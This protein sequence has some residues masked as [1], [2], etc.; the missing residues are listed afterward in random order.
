MNRRIGGYYLIGALLLAGAGC[1]LRPIGWFLLW[2]AASLFVVAAGY[3]GI[4]A[5]VYGKRAGKLPLFPR[6]LHLFT[7]LGHELSRRHY[8][9]ACRPWCSLAPE[10]RIGRQLNETEAEELREEG[11]TAVLDLCAEFSEPARLRSLHYLNI[12]IL[13]LTA[14]TDEQ[15]RR[16]LDFLSERKDS[17]G[18]AYLH[19][20]IGYSRTAAVAGSYLLHSGRAADADEAIARLRKA[21]PSMVIRPEAEATI[22]RYA[23]QCHPS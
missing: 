1:W 3:A 5:R 22:R 13:D 12:P 21:R 7:L 23:G 4:G 6:L 19:C 10:I 15:L 9:K 17:G 8:A 20:K 14:P 2:P 11:V 16:A 18:I